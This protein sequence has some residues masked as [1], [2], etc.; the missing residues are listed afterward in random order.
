MNRTIWDSL[1]QNGW[2]WCRSG[3]DR[4]S[5]GR[6]SW[7]RSSLYKSSQDR[8]SKK[9]KLFNSVQVKMIKFYLGLECGPTQTYLFSLYIWMNMIH[10]NRS[11]SLQYWYESLIH[12]YYGLF[13]CTSYIINITINYNWIKG[14]IFMLRQE[15]YRTRFVCLSVCQSVC[16]SSKF[17]LVGNN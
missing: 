10:N 11:I 15:A 9:I 1:I 12:N 17:N 14:H 6:T 16:L 7:D 4:S 3:L 8:S 2:N 5:Q 13:L